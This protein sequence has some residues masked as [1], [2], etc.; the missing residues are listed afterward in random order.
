MLKKKKNRQAPGVLSIALQ[1]AHE[2]FGDVEELLQLHR[3]GSDS[4]EWRGRRLE[5][6]FEPINFPQKVYD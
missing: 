1:E 3:Q 2:I 4:S 5:D 6:E